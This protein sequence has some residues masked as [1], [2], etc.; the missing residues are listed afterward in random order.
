MPDPKKITSFED[1]IAKYGLTPKDVNAEILRVGKKQVVHLGRLGKKPSLYPPRSLRAGGVDDVKNW[2]G[3]PDSAFKHKPKMADRFKFEK[4]PSE[5]IL[6]AFTQLHQKYL[7]E[8]DAAKKRTLSNEIHVLIRKDRKQ[9]IRIAKAYVYGPSKDWAAWHELLDWLLRDFEFPLFLFQRVVVESGAVLE[10]DSG[11]NI[12][13]GDL[14][15]IEPGGTI[16]TSG[17]LTINFSELRRT[18]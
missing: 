16:R 10:L 8:K 1:R 4:P 18:L 6:K 11:N 9:I 7:K 2:I 13:T 3:T 17:S 14:L 15:V 12:L 5:N